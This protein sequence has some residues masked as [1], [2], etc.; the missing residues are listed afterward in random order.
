MIRH[1][2]QKAMSLDEIGKFI[3]KCDELALK[4]ISQL[5]SSPMMKQHVDRDFLNVFFSY[6]SDCEW[7][8]I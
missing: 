6:A 1:R 3:P 8:E 7:M 2:H 5:D 4:L